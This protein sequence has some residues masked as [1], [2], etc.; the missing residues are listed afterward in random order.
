MTYESPSYAGTGLMADRPQLPYLLPFVA[1]VAFFLPGQ[2][3]H[4]FGIDWQALWWHWFGVV[5]FAKTVVAGALLWAFWKYY[6]PIRWTHLGLGAVVGLIGVPLW[7]G[8]EYL[9][10]HL[11]LHAAPDPAQKYALYDAVKEIPDTAW[12][13]AYYIVRVSGPTLVVPV[14]EELFF[15]DFVQRA[16]IR[17]A[18]FQEVPV[19]T[20]TW[21]SL[22]GMAALFGV[23]HGT[24]WPSGI[25]YGLMMGILLVRT[26]SLGACIVAHAVTNFVLYAGYCIPFH[27]WQFM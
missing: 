15:R 7:V 5:Y 2:L 16:L 20:F 25:L 3:G 17:G 24:M 23:N 19:G 12:R 14:M 21:A 27:D 1:Y 4:A 8:T 22:L 13:W 10:Q 11:G 9:A 18:R 6:T 26:R